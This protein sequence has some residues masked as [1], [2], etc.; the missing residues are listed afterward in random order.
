ME[1]YESYMGSNM[2]TWGQAVSSAVHKLH[3]GSQ[4]VG[5]HAGSLSADTEHPCS[6]SMKFL[7]MLVWLLEQWCAVLL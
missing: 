3:A 4:G 1:L 7:L 6:A 2:M 5:I